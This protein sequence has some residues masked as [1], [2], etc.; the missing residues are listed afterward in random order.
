[1]NTVLHTLVMCFLVFIGSAHPLHH[2]RHHPR[3]HASTSVHEHYR[4][5]GH[6]PPRKLAQPSAVEQLDAIIS[7]E[8]A[9]MARDFWA[10]PTAENHAALEKMLSGENQ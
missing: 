1:M 6:K 3:L 5:T 7:E 10:N 4:M 2:H 8:N 9:D